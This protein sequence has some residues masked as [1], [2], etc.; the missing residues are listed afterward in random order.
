MTKIRRAA[1]CAAGG[2][3]SG[4]MQATRNRVLF[5]SVRWRDL[6]GP[7]ERPAAADLQSVSSVSSVAG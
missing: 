2:R 7:A 4:R 6:Q 1:L 5:A 3:S